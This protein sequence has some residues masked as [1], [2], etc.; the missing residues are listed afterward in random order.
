MGSQ[1]MGD[2]GAAYDAAQTTN[3]RTESPNINTTPAG[4]NAITLRFNFIH[5]GQGATDRCQLLY[6][7]N[8]GTSWLML[9]N[10]IPKAPCC[11]GACDGQVQGQWTGRSYVLPASCN[12]ITNFRIAFNWINDASGGT[13]PSFGVDD[14]TLEYTAPLPVN[15][16]SFQGS[17]EES[18]VRLTWSTASEINSDYFEVQRSYNAGSFQALG[19]VKGSGNSNRVVNYSFVDG[20]ME[21]G[22]AYYRLKQVDFNG[23]FTY[24]DMI[25]V[26]QDDIDEEN[27]VLLSTLVSDNLSYA[28]VVKEQGAYTVEI[29][30]G[31][32][33]LVGKQQ[34]KLTKG[35]NNIDFNTMDLESGVYYLILKRDTDARFISG[36]KFV[37]I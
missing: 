9:E 19:K 25:A 14:I 5:F 37:K 11:G 34:L 17:S 31:S 15:W 4:T 30:D 23:S 36:N 6:S 27:L 32:G 16:L 20:K 7:I 8:G 2:I 26:S 24:S 12:N 10:P 33:K 1:S 21:G 3:R 29:S 18:V 13:D 35:I 28:V 22:I